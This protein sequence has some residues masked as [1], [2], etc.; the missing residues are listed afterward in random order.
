MLDWYRSGMKVR[1]LI[2]ESLRLYGTR[3]AGAYLLVSQR[4]AGILPLR[5]NAL[6]TSAGKERTN[7]YNVQSFLK[8]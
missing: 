6:R 2:S 5:E 3:P 4:N 8:H 1:D 7:D